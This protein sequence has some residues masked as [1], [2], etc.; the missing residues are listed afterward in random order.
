MFRKIANSWMMHSVTKWNRSKTAKSHT[1]FNPFQNNHKYTFIYL[2]WPLDK[3][4]LHSFLVSYF[5]LRIRTEYIC[6]VCSLNV[7]VFKDVQG[8]QIG[9]SN[10]NHNIHN[11]E[12]NMREAQKLI[13]VLKLDSATRLNIQYEV[14]SVL[15]NLAWLA[16]HVTQTSKQFTKS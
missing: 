16:A 8:I 10:E 13:W 3:S 14:W 5:C 9:S 1:H 4:Q 12:S 7:W 6:V 2:V 11:L 15:I